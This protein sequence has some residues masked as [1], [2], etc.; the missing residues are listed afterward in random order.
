MQSSFNS[1]TRLIKLSNASNMSWISDK[2]QPGGRSSEA[3]LVAVNKQKFHKKERAVNMATV[4]NLIPLSH[5][6]LLNL[7][8]FY[9][10]A[11]HLFFVSVPVGG[12]IR[13]NLFE[14]FG[15]AAP[16]HHQIATLLKEI[17]LTL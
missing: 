8:L 12:V 5:P 15:P 13:K 6:S 4:K 14:S 9:M 16:T 10:S 11:N 17:L 2:G 7:K 3:L 1:E